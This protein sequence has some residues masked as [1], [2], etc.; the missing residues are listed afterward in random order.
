[1]T[2]DARAMTATLRR[3]RRTRAL[4][5]SFGMLLGMV[6]TTFGPQMAH[7]SRLRF[8]TP[9]QGC[10]CQKVR[11]PAAQAGLAPGLSDAS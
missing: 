1:V 6:A 3:Q 2:F 8:T 4:A 11:L 7:A 10:P 9:A 5:M